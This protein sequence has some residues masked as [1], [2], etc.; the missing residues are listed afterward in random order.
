M[1]MNEVVELV[2]RRR[3]RAERTAKVAEQEPWRI[4][5]GDDEASTVAAQWRARAA[6]CQALLVELRALT[7][8]GAAE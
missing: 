2:E 3:A 4:G 7:A 6:E 8:A 1:R 5:L